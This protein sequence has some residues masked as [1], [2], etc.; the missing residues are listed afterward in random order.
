MALSWREH[1]APEQVSANY[2]RDIHM[3]IPDNDPA[4]INDSIE[5]TEN[6][7][8]ESLEITVNIPDHTYWGDIDIRLVSPAGTEV[9][10]ASPRYLSSA[11]LTSGYHHWTLGD[12]LHAG[13]LS[14]GTWRLI[15]SDREAADVGTLYS[16]G[17]KIYGTAVPETV[18]SLPLSCTPRVFE[19]GA[20]S[21][22]TIAA[23]VNHHGSQFSRQAS[24]TEAED[25]IVLFGLQDVLS[26][27][28]YHALVLYEP[29]GGQTTLYVKTATGWMMWDG[30]LVDLPGFLPSGT[31]GSGETSV[32]FQG[33]L[34]PGSYT[35]YSGYTSQQGELIYCPEPL[36]I[37]VE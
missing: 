19:T 23:G 2:V 17:M 11:S 26:I 35:I 20:T 5:V 6:L 37:T 28:K 21:V 36:Q 13:E 16:W 22:G 3:D 34:S 1:L 12:V 29:P 14:R 24:G 7:R 15:V 30:G 8:V 4:G 10:L 18:A 33:R 31:P 32:L 25:F 27:L 9:Q